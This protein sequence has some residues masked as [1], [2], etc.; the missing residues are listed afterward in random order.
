VWAGTYGGLGLGLH[1]GLGDRVAVELYNR[2]D[3]VGWYIRRVGVRVRVTCRVR[4]PGSCRA[5]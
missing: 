3:S 2:V 4:G 1:V 5:V